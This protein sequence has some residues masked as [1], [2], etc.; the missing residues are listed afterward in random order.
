MAEITT[1]I[2]TYRRPQLLQRAVTSVLNQTY[3]NIVIYIFDNAS[4]DTTSSIVQSLQKQDSRIQYICREKNIGLIQNFCQAVEVVKT[5]FF[6]FFSDDDFLLPWFYETALD[7]LS[8]YPQAG[9]S[10]CRTLLVNRKGKLLPRQFAN[11]FFEGYFQPPE[12][13]LNFALMQPIWTGTLFRKEVLDSIGGLEDTVGSTFDTIFHF[14]AAARFPVILNKK[15]G[16]LFFVWEQSTS[17]QQITQTIW[18]NYCKMRRMILNDIKLSSP[19]RDQI[20]IILNCHRDR[21][22]RGIWLRALLHKDVSAAREWQRVWAE[23]GSKKDRLLDWV[24]TI[25]DKVP[26]SIY[27]FQSALF[28][29]R[30]LRQFIFYCWRKLYICPDTKLRD[31]LSCIR[32]EK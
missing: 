29:I 1:L 31:C 18:L 6:H 12:S 9:L 14:K 20:E 3:K 28:L 16:A 30:S 8:K 7:D 17:S 21:W 27:F 22:Q 2:P 19:L 13:L 11:S 10:H 25:C 15:P 4:G 5:P 26:L 24:L 32:L 23:Q